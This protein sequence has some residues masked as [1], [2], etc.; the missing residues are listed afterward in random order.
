MTSVVLLPRPD[1]IAELTRGLDL[2]LPAIDDVY[3][4]IIAD[5]LAQAFKDIRQSALHTILT[6]S[7]AEVT[8]L[9]EAR[10]NR[11]IE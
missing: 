11:M 10:L 5:Y 3:L 8:A 1:Q 2:P 4:N 7:E 6:G 9:L